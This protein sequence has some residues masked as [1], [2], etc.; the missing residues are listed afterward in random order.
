MTAAEAVLERG[1][2]L[3]ESQATESRVRR[4]MWPIIVSVVF[5]ATG[6]AYTFLWSPVVRH[7]TGW[8]QPGDIWGTYRASQFISWGDIGDVYQ[9]NTGFISYPGIALLLAPVALLTDHFNLVG[10]FPYALP[11]PSAWPILAPIV[12][13]TG[14]VP[15]FAF[16][17][18]AEHL[19]VTRSPRILM[20]WV[21][22]VILWP[23]LV[24]WGHP[25]DSIALG[26][27]AYALL[28]AWKRRWRATGWLLGAA[29]LFQPLVV[30]I[31]PLILA[32]LPNLRERL[33]CVVRAV[34]PAAVFLAIPLVESW[35]A[36]TTALVKQ[37]TFPSIDHSTPFLFLAPVIGHLKAAVGFG[38]V[39]EGSG[40]RFITTIAHGQGEI[41]APGPARILALAFAAGTGIYAWRRRPSAAVIVW[42]CALSLSVWCFVEP[43]MTPYYVWPA[44]G[45]VVLAGS[46]RSVLR[47]GLIAIGATF[48]TV[49]VEQLYSTWSWWAPAI[50]VLG[51]C[52][53]LAH[54]NG[55]ASAEPAAGDN[56][57][58][59]SAGTVEG[60]APALS[61]R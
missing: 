47:F 24:L 16:D 19:S 33:L 4:R 17:A 32:L 39:R 9:D 21:Q 57:S 50:G 30:L 29:F 38:F 31:A 45:F 49:W 40:G 56:A 8:V 43:V 5:V 7:K 55:T 59:P 35:T 58:L 1:G 22:G 15:L 48:V 44:L 41:V 14:L 46:T 53:F 60:A 36:T 42:L 34:V 52:L 13:L 23:M 51:V 12:L 37:P 11:H 10:S 2:G 54:P 26:L 18:I 25:E 3:E 28:A 6:L 20:C 27:G 61:T